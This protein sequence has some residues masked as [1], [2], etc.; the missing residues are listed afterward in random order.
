M[1][2][3]VTDEHDQLNSHIFLRYDKQVE[4]YYSLEWN[5]NFSVDKTDEIPIIVSKKPVEYWNKR[6]IHC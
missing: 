4:V 3:A 6:K 5:P 1:V 2:V